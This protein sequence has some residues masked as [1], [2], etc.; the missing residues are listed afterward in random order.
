MGPVLVELG[1]DIAIRGTPP[2]NEGWQVAVESGSGEL[3]AIL[4]IDRGAVATSSTE[5]IRWRMNGSWSHHIIDP[6]N[7]EPSRSDVRQVTALGDRTASTEV[8]AKT[9]LILGAEG[10]A[11]LVADN[12]GLELLL[13][14]I[15]GAAVGTPRMIAAASAVGNRS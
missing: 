7:G 14:P 2:T 15:T 12:P 13:V 10:S 6:M 11:R 9:A 8:W 1:G 5:K 3:L 4:D